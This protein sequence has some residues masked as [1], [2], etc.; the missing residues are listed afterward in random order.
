MAS[1][2][3]FS[4]NVPKM[5]QNVFKGKQK[6]CLIK[7]DQSLIILILLLFGIGISV[8]LWWNK[9]KIYANV[10]NESLGL[11]PGYWNNTTYYYPYYQSS[12]IPL[13]RPIWRPGPI[14]G[15]PGRGRGGGPGRGR[16]GG[17]GRGGG[18]GPGR[19]GG[20]GGGGRR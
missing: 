11:D 2:K 1:D 7:M 3:Q 6:S 19:G 9:N 13:R 17:P 15:G 20:R 4:Q 14:R 5:S 18:G 8:V 16:G 12:V 10:F